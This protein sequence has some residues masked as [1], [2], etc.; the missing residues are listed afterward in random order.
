[1]VYPRD[2]EQKIGFT[3]LRSMLEAQCLSEMGRRYCRNMAMMVDY[4]RLLP[5]L[6]Q[7]A[8]MK[9]V[10][11]STALPLQALPDP[12]ESLN[13]LK[14]EGSHVSAEKFG[15]LKAFLHTASQLRKFF[16]AES[17]NASSR[18]Q[19]TRRFCNIP[20]LTEPFEAIKR[21]VNDYGQVRDNASPLLADIRRRIS[22]AS[23][24]M[25]GMLRRVMDT[26]IKQASLPPTPLLNAR[27]ASR[28][29]RNGTE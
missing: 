28:N 26:A 3:Q 12:S 20:D 11:A 10:L 8:E 24:A 5:V 25:Q 15:E 17:D 9:A 16:S 14:A 1:M 2:F 23:S 7:V 6:L 19:L 18:P 22:A 4:S 13:L 27:R 29:P 21:V